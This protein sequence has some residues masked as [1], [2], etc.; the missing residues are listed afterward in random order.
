MTRPNRPRSLAVRLTLWYAGSAFSILLVATGIL[1]WALVTNLDRQD[2]QF[3]IDE[4][5][6]LQNLLA[7]RPEYV[8][9]IRQE[10]EWEAAARR[11]ARVYVR[12][13]DHDGRSV[14]ETPKMRA[15]LPADK[16]PGAVPEADLTGGKDATS[17][18]GTPYRVLAAHVAN[19]SGTGIHTIHVAVDRVQQQSL[20]AMYRTTLLAVLLIALAAS[21]LAAYLIAR[22]GIQPIAKVAATARRIR[23]TTLH[24][25]IE[26]SDFPAELSELADTFNEMLDRLQESFER[27]SRFSAD[28]AHEL[29][30]PVNNL[31]GEAEVTLRKRRSSE[32][33]RESLGSCLEESVRL[34]QIIDGL[35]LMARAEMPEAELERE[36]V[37]LRVELGAFGEFYEAAA[38][39]AGLR[40]KMDAKSGLR[41]SANRPLLQRAIGNL[42]ENAIAHTPAGGEIRMT[43]AEDIARIFVTVS[44]TGCGIPAEDVPHV[45]DRFYRV[46]H[47]RSSTTGGSGLGLAIVRSIAEWHGGGVELK[48][49]MDGTIV[50]FWLPRN[51]PSD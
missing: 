42:V 37:D 48:S 5:H 14:A 39:E 10:V 1:Y 2:D 46:E 35:L 32:E 25:R 8:D 38:A 40:L 24:E 31:R 23:S 30:T 13:I 44:D 6:I 11:Y 16:F 26:A 33:Y 9:A 17:R 3:L 28:I 20:V 12:L 47:D 49:G 19:A 21:S 34:S 41:V 29:R 43:T 45:F 27:L 22:H 51:F 36:A 50:T 15:M 4:V 18:D 7:E